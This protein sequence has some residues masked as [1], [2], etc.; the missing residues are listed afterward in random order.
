[1]LPP[2]KNPSDA[3][4]NNF[5]IVFP[6]KVIVS[7]GQIISSCLYVRL[8]RTASLGSRALSNAGE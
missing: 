1:M 7:Y 2:G 8:K 3:H 6:A 5:Y 4:G